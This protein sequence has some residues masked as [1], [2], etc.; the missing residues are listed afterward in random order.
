MYNVVS[1]TLL[2]QSDLITIFHCVIYSYHDRLLYCVFFYIVLLI[3]FICLQW[4]NL[5]FLYFKFDYVSCYLISWIFM[6]PISLL[7][8]YVASPSTIRECSELVISDDLFV[9]LL[10]QLLLQSNNDRGQTISQ[11]L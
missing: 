4:F 5:L 3:L 8:H 9:S 10:L 11:E 6:F 7:L 1:I 2:Q